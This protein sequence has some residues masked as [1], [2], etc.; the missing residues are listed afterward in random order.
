MINSKIN[1]I[2]IYGKDSQGL[3]ENHE[4]RKFPFQRL[5]Q[6]YEK[7]LRK[8]VWDL[9]ENSAGVSISFRT[10]SSELSVKWTIKSD[11]SMNHMT[12][13]GIKGIDLYYKENGRWNYLSSGIPSGKRNKASLF[14]GLSV[15]TR[16]CR[17]HLPLYESVTSLQIGINEA[18]FFEI[19]MDKDLP[20][21]FYGT[22]ITQGGCASRPGIAHT[23]AISRILG[24][25]CI[26]LGFSGNGHM[27]VSLGAIIAKIKAKLIVIECMAN[28]DIETI[29]KNTIPLIQAI[30]KTRQDKVPGIVFI[31]EAITNNRNPNQKYLQS[32]HKK[33]KELKEQVKIAERSGHNGVYIISQVGL[34]DKDTE[35]TV[36]G[37]HYNDL[38]FERH[39]T[40]L[41]NSFSKLSL[42]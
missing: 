37:T 2:D 26:N 8:E 29:R 15:K 32:I 39:T 17:L 12:A 23:N 34:I 7:S 11:F 38:G 22:S 41:V 1:Y 10:N 35:A 4:E 33:N 5:P 6:R 21:V 42:V 31:E 36:D 18:S 3:V 40:H 25:E 13:V 28:V 14:K 27:E 19:I 24:F 16:E 30:R 20:I 9:S